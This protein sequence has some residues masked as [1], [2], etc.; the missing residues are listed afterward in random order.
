MTGV[1]HWTLTVMD[2]SVRHSDNILMSFL[3]KNIVGPNWFPFLQVTVLEARD[4]I[5][6]RV[7]DDDEMSI[8]VG[9]GAMIIVGHINNPITLLCEQVGLGAL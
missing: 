2:T 8:R 9:H 7:W 5:G 3:F 4:R 6:G 1:R